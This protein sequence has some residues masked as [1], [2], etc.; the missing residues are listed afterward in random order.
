MRVGLLSVKDEGVWSKVAKAQLDE[1]LRL[2]GE[3]IKHQSTR[4]KVEGAVT[5]MNVSTL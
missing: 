2:R 4:A 1:D 3:R 5:E